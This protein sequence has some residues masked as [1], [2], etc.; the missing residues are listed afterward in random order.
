M[1]KK[2]LGVMRYFNKPYK[3]F[4]KVTKFKWGS[5][6]YE[7]DSIIFAATGEIVY[8]DDSG[9]RR[10]K[11]EMKRYLYGL[12]SDKK[13]VNVTETTKQMSVPQLLQPVYHITEEHYMS[14]GK[15]SVFVEAKFARYVSYPEWKGYPLYV[16][17]TVNWVH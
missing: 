11:Q 1:E 4:K 13:V 6:E 3:V 9:R 8:I 12:S 15:E 2:Y 16:A 14:K 17:H 10:N 5:K 7:P